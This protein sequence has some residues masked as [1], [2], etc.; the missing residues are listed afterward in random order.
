MSSFFVIGP[1][2]S[3]A[4]NR[5]SNLLAADGAEVLPKSPELQVDFLRKILD[6]PRIAG[7]DREKLQERLAGKT[8]GQ[9][10][11]DVEGNDR[12]ARR[13]ARPGRNS[14]RA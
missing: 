11:K 13:I 14:R 6:F 5:I 12:S 3:F 4:R 7:T 1:F 8:G 2:L 10:A 9:H